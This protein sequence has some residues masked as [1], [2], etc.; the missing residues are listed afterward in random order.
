MTEQDA[1]VARL[2]D[3]VLKVYPKTGHALDWQWHDSVSASYHKFDPC[4]TIDDDHSYHGRPSSIVL[5]RNGYAIA[6]T[7]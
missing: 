1:L 7:K 3:A 4:L 6:C 2:A 5:S